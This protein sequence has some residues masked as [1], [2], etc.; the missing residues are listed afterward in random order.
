MK[1]VI[2]LIILSVGLL[3][4]CNK[5][6]PVN[7]E[8]GN[9]QVSYINLEGGFYGIKTDDGKNLEP[10]NLPEE[11]KTD[12]I[13]VSFNYKLRTDLAS[14]RMWGTIVEIIEIKRMGN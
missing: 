12:G 7:Y 11:F 5:Q 2:I 6:N 1:R 3:L 8:S 13:R 4:G 14:C 9:G 10:I